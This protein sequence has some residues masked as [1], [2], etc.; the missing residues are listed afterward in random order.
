M[1]EKIVKDYLLEWKMNSNEGKII[2]IFE[3]GSDEK[4]DG[5]EVKEF[6]AMTAVLEK[7]ETMFDDDDKTLYN[8]M[9]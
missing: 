2:F 8:V 6:T 1:S 9:P 5:L 3:D 7:G 4:L